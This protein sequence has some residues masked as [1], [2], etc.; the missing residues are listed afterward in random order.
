MSRRHVLR[1]CS[2]LH[3]EPP[4]KVFSFIIEKKEDIFIWCLDNL[5]PCGVGLLVLATLSIRGVCPPATATDWEGENKKE[6]FQKSD[7][8]K[9][10][11]ELLDGRRTILNGKKFS[12]C[13][14]GILLATCQ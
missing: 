6:N 8:V 10:K 14:I 4:Q 3:Y 11:L 12:I 7:N 13:V 9:S 2:C 1:T 5:E